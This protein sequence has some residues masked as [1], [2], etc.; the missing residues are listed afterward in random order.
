MSQRT[1]SSANLL[2]TMFIAVMIF[3]VIGALKEAFAATI[4]GTGTASLSWDRPTESED[5]LALPG[6]PPPGF[7]PTGVVPANLRG[8]HRGKT[9]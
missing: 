5:G 9:A 1:K 7:P 3:L 8:S 4:T 2:R 6:R